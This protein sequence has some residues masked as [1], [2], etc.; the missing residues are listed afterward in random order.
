MG[1]GEEL[2]SI[3]VKEMGDAKSIIEEER[4]KEKEE[5]VL[6]FGSVAR[7]GPEYSPV[8][9]LN[10]W[11]EPLNATSIENTVVIKDCQRMLGKECRKDSQ[12]TE[13]KD[14]KIA[15]NGQ[16]WTQWGWALQWKCTQTRV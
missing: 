5:C 1:I 14:W 4:H 10:K 8:G 15:W 6:E 16:G 3:R 9:R 13:R 2:F 11:K 7:T 12:P